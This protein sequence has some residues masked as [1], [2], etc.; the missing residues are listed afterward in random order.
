MII[1]FVQLLIEFE[2]GVNFLVRCIAPEGE[3]VAVALSLA[4]WVAKVVI[5]QIISQ[6]FARDRKCHDC[7][8]KL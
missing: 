5:V 4:R 6:L 3:S 7:K 1:Y 8:K 2:P